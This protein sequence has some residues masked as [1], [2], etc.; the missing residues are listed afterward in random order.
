MVITYE[1]KGNLYINI[2]N[3][4][5]NRCSF[6]IRDIKD[7][8]LNDLWLERE[9]SIEDIK[10]DI[11]KRDLEKYNQLVFCG[12]GEP[13]ER[14]DTLIE[15]CKR[16]KEKS[17]IHIRINTNGLAN[18]IYKS[19]VTPYLEG[20][21]DSLSVSLNAPNA[22]EYDEICS[23]VF[24]LDAFPAILDFIDKAKRYVRDIQ[25]SVVDCLLPEKIQ[26]CN[27][28]AQELN[29]KIKIRHL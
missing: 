10:C 23:S 28:I 25:V 4:C 29:V 20:L 16:V 7:G 26:E 2:T 22:K 15:V 24:G 27:K 17:S 11:L 3:K 13:F 19:D 21:V 1:L 6:C 14:F 8:F 9:P 12:F 5:S 18:L